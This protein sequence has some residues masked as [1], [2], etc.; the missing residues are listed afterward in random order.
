MQVKKNRSP[1]SMED[2][3]NDCFLDLYN[4]AYVDLRTS[5]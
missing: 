1:S 2:I 5:F 4:L 3:P